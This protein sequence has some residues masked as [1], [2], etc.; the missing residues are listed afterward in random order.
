MYNVAL[1]LAHAYDAIQKDRYRKS[2]DP[3]GTRDTAT[4]RV[5]ANEEPTAEGQERAKLIRE[6]LVS[7]EQ[8]VRNE[9]AAIDVA[10]RKVEE[11][12]DDQDKRAAW[13]LE[14]N[15]TGSMER[16]CIPLALSGYAK[17][18]H[19]GLLAYMPLAYERYLEWKAREEKREAERLAAAEASEHVGTV[20]QRITIT[21]ATAKLVT[22]WETMYGVTRLY[23]FTDD[24]GNVFVWRASKSIEISDGMKIK[25]TVKDHS[26]YGGVKQTVITR[27]A[28]A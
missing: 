10:W 19:F 8:I 25:G 13:K 2:S 17:T 23:K 24:Q 21:A 18:R 9:D 7:L 15:R 11:T 27:C 28:V 20:G 14:N 16:N 6:W 5:L 3:G 26:E 22:S 4:A 1:V 12:D